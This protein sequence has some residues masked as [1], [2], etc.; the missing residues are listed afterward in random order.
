MAAVIAV[1]GLSGQENDNFQ[2]QQGEERESGLTGLLRRLD[3]RVRRVQQDLEELRVLAGDLPSPR[4]ELRHSQDSARAALLRINPNAPSTERPSLEFRFDRPRRIDEIYLIRL[5]HYFELIG[6]NQPFEPSS[7]RPGHFEIEFESGGNRQF[8]AIGDINSDRT[9]PIRLPIGR[10]Q[11][12]WLRLGFGSLAGDETASFAISEIFL[13]SGETNLAPQAEVTLRGALEDETGWEIG[14]ATDGRHWLGPPV[15][16]EEVEIFGHLSERRPIG[17]EEWVELNFPTPVSADEIRVFPGQLPH[18]PGPTEHFFPRQLLIEGWAEGA[19]EPETI[20]D[21]NAEREGELGANTLDV[22]LPDRPWKRFRL[23]GAGLN[24]IDGKVIFALGEVQV[25]SGL[26][27]LAPRAELSAS[28]VARTPRWNLAGLTDGRTAAGR[29]ETLSNWLEG[30]NRSARVQQELRYLESRLGRLTEFWRLVSAIAIVSVMGLILL[31]LLL[32]M[33][34]FRRKRRR[35]EAELRKQLMMD[36]HDEFG[37]NLGVL[38]LIAGQLK[39]EQGNENFWQLLDRKLN[40]IVEIVGTSRALLPRIVLA[41]E[42]TRPPLPNAIEDMLKTQLEDR[43]IDFD[44]AEYPRSTTL[45]K[46]VEEALYLIAKES[47]HNCAKHSGATEIFARLAIEDGGV[48]F[49]LDDNGTWKGPAKKGGGFGLRSL[50][51]RAQ[52]VGGELEISTSEKGTR[53]RCFVPNAA[54]E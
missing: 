10:D 9:L 41:S 49:E 14:Y 50:E 6:E 7:D 3:P 40:Q 43:E 13:L 27:N 53:L 31:A 46:E 29:I 19:S 37:G 34:R 36:L 52:K 2:Q 45:A 4:V 32:Q 1:S 8:L 11:I 26:E 23:T 28:S 51:K 25:I 48:R 22:A 33:A 20:L 42:A 12:S 21:W 24:E 47:I 18:F 39:E 16:S 44:D 38:A 35:A 15:V 30:V 54:S 17:S 5:P